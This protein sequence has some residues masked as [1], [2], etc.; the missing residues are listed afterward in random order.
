MSIHAIQDPRPESWVVD[1]TGT[2][3]PEDRAEIDDV[4]RRVDENGGE[5]VVV[6]V[7]NLS[8]RQPR[9]FATELGNLWHL[10]P[11]GVLIL[12]AKQARAAEIVLGNDVDGRHQVGTSRMIMNF[13][14]V[15]AFR[16]GNYAEGLLNGARAVERRLLVAEATPEPR[17]APAQA[18]PL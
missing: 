15:P 5:L 10:N 7:K 11:R 12:V 1:L 9:R 17:G 13:I 6:V 2:L 4:A 3:S 18:L 16:S 8:G 14:L